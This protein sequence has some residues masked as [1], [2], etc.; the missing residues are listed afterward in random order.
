MTNGLA[1][2]EEY[3]RAVGAEMIETRFPGQKERIAV[4]LAG[5]GSECFGFDDEYSRDHDWG[6]GF[7]MWL[8]KNDHDA[9]GASLQQAYEEL[10]AQ[11]MGYERK[12]SRWGDGRVGV[13]DT[14]AFYTSFIGVATAPETY[15]Q[16]LSI[17]EANLAA[18][19][20]GKVFHDPL[21]Q[22]SSIRETIKQHYPEDVRLKKIAARCMTAAQ[23]GQYNYRRC[24][25]R[26]AGYPAHHSLVKF[27]EDILALVFL[28]NRRFMPFYKWSCR[29]AEALPTLGLE[30][31]L[32]VEALL[33]M[34]DVGD[35][36]D[37]IEHMCGRVI[38]LLRA[39]GLSDSRSG[40]LLDHGP[41]VHSLIRDE[42]LKRID[43]WWVGG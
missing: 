15:T 42:E 17:P 10:P 33:S 34:R 11:F 26:Q 8:E 35:R 28:L 21:G 30:M 36:E 20:N 23:S 24:T 43:I 14:G 41:R 7:C 40:F 22:F 31:A 37:A 38:E 18:C 12:I 25:Q 4:G 9:I 2:S 16:W 13:L 6:P 39:Q 5:L 3:Y 1:L 27:C 29:A 19:S 32:T